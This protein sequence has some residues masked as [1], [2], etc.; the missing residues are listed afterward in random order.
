MDG[1][2]RG[3]LPGGVGEYFYV[4]IADVIGRLGSPSRDLDADERNGP[5][6][7]RN[8]HEG[9]RPDQKSAQTRVAEEPE[10]RAH[11]GVNDED[12]ALPEHDHMP[13]PEQQERQEPAN[14][15]RTKPGTCLLGPQHL[16]GEAQSEQKRKQREELRL[17]QEN[18]GKKR[19]PFVMR[20]GVSQAGWAPGCLEYHQ[21][22]REDAI[23]RKSA[24]DI[25]DRQP[26]RS[27]NGCHRVSQGVGLAW[28]WAVSSRHALSRLMAEQI[29]G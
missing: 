12:V 14:V 3:P 11:K 20:A 27:G 22:D 29:T 17:D 10:E 15:A 23:E 19:E 2:D 16:N 8:G 9:A 13:Y 18:H 28:H 1:Q 24:Q 21:V 7:E 5:E 6:Q 25:D 4:D 26:F